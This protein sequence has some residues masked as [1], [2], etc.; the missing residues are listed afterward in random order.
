MSETVKAFN[1]LEDAAHETGHPVSGLVHRAVIERL[2]ARTDL[3][4]RAV[5]LS[6]SQQP[7]EAH[8][9]WLQDVVNELNPSANTTNPPKPDDSTIEPAR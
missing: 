4:R 8:V 3:L 2:R 1:E 5:M 6:S 9:Q 7:L